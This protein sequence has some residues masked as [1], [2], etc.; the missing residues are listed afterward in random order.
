M[1]RK[2]TPESNDFKSKEQLYSLFYELTS[3]LKGKEIELDE[4]EYLDNIKTIKLSQLIG[5]LRDTI[6]I[7]INKQVEEAK[8]IIYKK[9]YDTKGDGCDVY[10]M[11][12]MIQRYELN[13]KSLIKRFYK[14]R[15]HKEA[16]ENKIEEYIEMEEEFEE[17]KA[18]LKYEDGK[19]LENDR[20]DNEIIILR[21][22]NTNLKKV[23]SNLELKSKKYEKEMNDRDALI[24]QL[25]D[26]VD[27]LKTKLDR[28]QKELNLFSNININF[29]NNSNTSNNTNSNINQ[30]KCSY[31]GCGSRSTEKGSDMEQ[32]Q[33]KLFNSKKVKSQKQNNIA[34]YS[35]NSINGSISN[36]IINYDIF[37]NKSSS[38]ST[39]KNKMNQ[40]NNSMSLRNDK[41]KGDLINKFI[42]QNHIFNN[43]NINDFKSNCIKIARLPINQ[44]N[45][46]IINNNNPISR[47]DQSSTKIL[48]SKKPSANQIN[49]K[50]LLS[51]S[52]SKG[53]V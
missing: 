31:C 40:H 5:Y 18:N 17:M 30:I 51:N 11:E 13:E 9:N 24:D 48:L 21:A 10:Q 26:T 14:Q 29:S 3:E 12:K 49:S 53:E 19:F 1:I 45:C 4:E 43:T 36:S 47:R 32:T 37:S 28:T 44:S 23:I 25:K 35:L 38:S 16:L 41:F 20:K 2:S 7:L 22:E 33:L 34:Q 52:H 15:T 50:S 39:S 42:N 8:S 27:E 6:Q 46:P